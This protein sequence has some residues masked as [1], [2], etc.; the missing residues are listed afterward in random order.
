[1]PNSK[2]SILLVA[3]ERSGDVYGGQLASKLRAAMPELEIFGGGG[4]AM[5]RG[6]VETVV[7]ARQFAMV[8][9]TEVV[10]GLPRAYRAFHHLLREAERRKPVLAVLIDSPSLNMRLAQRLKRLGIPVVYFISPQIW[11]WKKWR[12]RHL[13]KLVDHMICIFDFEEKIYRKAGIPVTYVGHPLAERVHPRRS[14]E[15][16]FAEAGL[17]QELPLVALLPGSRSI[18]LC[19]NLPPMIHAAARLA[20]TSHVQFV[21]ALAPGH[22]PQEIEDRIRRIDPGALPLRVLPDCAYDALAYAAAAVVASGTATVEAALLECPMVVVYRVSPI[23]AFFA[24]FM[25]DVPYYSMVNLLAAKR[26]VAELIQADLTAERLEA[27]L[28]RLLDSGVCREQMRADLRA[29]HQRLGR[30]GAMEGAAAAVMNM[31][32]ACGLTPKAP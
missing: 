6:G 3:G 14:R 23:T 5:R 16:F 4:E 30:G 11:A 1:M 32:S 28:R 29:I 27:E 24:R 19:Y 31:L 8:G 20:K 12:L 7:D 9:I 18:E 26:V 17:G 21:L 10:S 13:T 15:Q 2:P 22:D 25:V